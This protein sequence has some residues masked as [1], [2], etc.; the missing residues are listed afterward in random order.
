MREKLQRLRSKL[1]RQRNWLLHHDNTSSHTSS[2][3]NFFTKSNMNVVNHPPYSRVKFS[4]YCHFDAS[5]VI[6]A[7]SQ[8]VLNA[9][10]K[11]NFQDALKKMAETL[12]TAH[13]C[14]RGLTGR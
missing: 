6:K 14:R 2:P 9:L 5:E 12:R 3:E 8:A 1:W 7:E 10:T 4:I 13:K 11:H